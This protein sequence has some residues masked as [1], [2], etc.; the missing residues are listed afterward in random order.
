MVL[1]AERD[2]SDR[3]LDRIVVKVD[4]AVGQETAEG[5]PAGEGVTD[6]LGE[7]AAARDATKLHLEPGLHR[8]DERPRLGIAYSLALFSGTSPDGLLDC[9]ELAHPAQRLGS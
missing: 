6:C 4:T 8:L 3:T 1:A 2:G 9:I 7:T 5:W